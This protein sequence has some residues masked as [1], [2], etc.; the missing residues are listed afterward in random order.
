MFTGAPVPAWMVSTPLASM[1]HLHVPQVPDAGSS[2]LGD[3]APAG[4]LDPDRG[5]SPLSTSEPSDRVGWGLESTVSNV[6]GVL[7]SGD[8]SASGDTPDVDVDCEGSIMLGVRS[9]MVG[10]VALAVIAGVTHRLLT[11]KVKAIIDLVGDVI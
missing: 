5:D 11:A 4:S 7:D 1:S 9:T 8:A 3:A 2:A 10:S 6:V